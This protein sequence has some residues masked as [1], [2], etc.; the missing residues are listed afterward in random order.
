MF[1]INSASLIRNGIALHNLF[2]KVENGLNIG[3]AFNE[4][5][6]MVTRESEADIWSFISA[7][8]KGI[9]KPS[10]YRIEMSL[11]PGASKDINDVNF[12]SRK[13]IIQAQEL[14]LNG[15]DAVSIKCHTMMIP[16]RGFDTFEVK[17]NNIRFKMPYG[18][19]YEPVTFSFYA[20]AELDTLRYFEIWQAAVMNYS[21]N[22]MNFFEEYVSDVNLYII[23]QEG[24]DVFG[25]KLVQA[26]PS[27]IGQI[28]LAYSN[29]NNLLN[30]NVTFNFRYFISLDNS[31]GIN[32]AY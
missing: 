12:K 30:I 4:V 11:P 28:D 3:N 29:V 16:R 18:I 7:F 22:T 27:N 19:T 25:V 1:N 2:N 6:S 9:A 21:S 31:S 23:D 8:N 14:S 10:R 13:G 17:Q 20:D 5:N 24:N 15:R 26:Y 32:R